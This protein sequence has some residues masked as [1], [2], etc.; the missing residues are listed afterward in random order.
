VTGSVPRTPRA[1]IAD[2][3]R[4]LA[5]AG[6]ASPRVEAEL[7]AAHVLG[8]PRSRLA[9]ADGLDA[10]ALDRYRE[11]VARRAA[12]VP[13]QHLTGVTAFRHLEFAV[14][15][16]VFIPRPETELLVSWALS[17]PDLPAAPV[18]ADLCAG[19][20]AIALSVAHEL[21]AARVYAVERDPDA[22]AWLRRNAAARAAA[23]DPPVTIV[24][25][26]VTDPA[27]TS[28]LDG[29]VDVLLCNPPYVPE[30]TPV[31]PEVG[32]HDP[33]AAVF[34]G[35]DGLAVIRPVV[36]RAAALLR[37][38]GL[39]AIEHDDSHGRAVPD[40]LHAAGAFEAVADHADLAG[41]ARFATARRRRSG[42]FGTLGHRDALRL[43]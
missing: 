33:H 11:L 16:G 24:Q 22:L 42:G 12:R 37:P 41:R 29:R 39:L 18:V 40:L 9:L 3:A 13:L 20:G 1:A 10:A 30:G 21:P 38:G 14:G 23:G 8:V 19:T 15:P 17:R 26:D 2:A 6:L 7:L 43:P 28:T 27:S 32:E 5:Q 31:P 35:P 4:V 25:G 36:A 34:G